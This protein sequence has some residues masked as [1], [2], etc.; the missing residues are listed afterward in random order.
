LPDTTRTAEKILSSLK[1]LRNHLQAGE[2]PILAQ[3][4]IW[5]NGQEST[6]TACD[7]VIT[8]Q[9]LLG[10]YFMSFPRERLF[11]DS[12]ALPAITHVTLRH[13][14]HSPIFEE[15]LV[16]DG[17]RKIY[18]RAPRKK[19]EAL[20]TALRSAIEQSTPTNAPASDTAS[21]D[22]SAPSPVASSSPAPIYGRQDIRTPFESSPLAITL[23]FGGG[24]LLEIIGVLLW[25]ITS[26]AQIGTPLCIAGLIAVLVSI[27]TMRQRRQRQ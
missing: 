18:I 9:R 7:V 23:L 13:K 22:T 25:S 3:P 16:S 1:G 17:Q 11:L 5:D 12:I 27:L 15:M 8:D 2:Q 6:S 14:T 21:T 4:A 26:S 24:L 19:I 20:H 10:Y